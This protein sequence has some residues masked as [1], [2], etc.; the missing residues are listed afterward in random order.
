MPEAWA[1]RLGVE[2]KQYQ[3]QRWSTLAG[4]IS[5]NREENFRIQPLWSLNNI[6]ETGSVIQEVIKQLN[7]TQ[8]EQS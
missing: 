2:E 3:R 8:K 4:T 7:K 1:E 5:Q 6:K